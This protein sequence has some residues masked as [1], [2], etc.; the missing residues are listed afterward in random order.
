MGGRAGVSRAFDV[1][2]AAAGNTVFVAWADDRNGSLDVYAN[3]SLDGGERYQPVDVRLDN[4]A[5]GTDGANPAIWA[6]TQSNGR[7]AAHVVWVDR[8]ND[9]LNGDIY[10][11]ALR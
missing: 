2:A 4:S 9:R 1:V 11:N 3:Y 10:Y 7:P 8:R 5:P 6:T